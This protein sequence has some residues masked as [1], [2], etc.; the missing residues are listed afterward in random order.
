MDN[1]PQRADTNFEFEPHPGFDRV[2]DPP[3]ELPP[4]T[5]A[6]RLWPEFSH[7]RRARQPKN[8]RPER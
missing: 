6:P 5:D 3:T 8:T 1:K 2:V 7:V 4:H